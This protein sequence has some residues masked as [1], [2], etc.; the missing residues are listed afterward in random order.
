[1]ADKR[2]E[3]GRH[4]SVVPKRVSPDKTYETSFSANIEIHNEIRTFIPALLPGFRQRPLHP[5]ERHEGSGPLQ[6]KRSGRA[7]SWIGE[8][9]FFGSTS[10]RN[11]SNFE[12]RKLYLETEPSE[13]HCSTSHELRHSRCLYVSLNYNV[14]L[15]YNLRG[16]ETHDHLEVWG[17]AHW[18]TNSVVRISFSLHWYIRKVLWSRLDWWMDFCGRSVIDSP[19]IH[20]LNQ[21]E[22]MND[23]VCR[24]IRV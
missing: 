9:F 17:K 24:R 15:K 21:W 1:M 4:E 6:S 5:V 23:K 3:K 12:S 18:R 19:N 11:I 8:F 16:N 14:E 13:I 2:I 7:C 10:G 22:L 20:A